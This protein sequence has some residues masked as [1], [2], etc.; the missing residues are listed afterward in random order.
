MMQK[1]ASKISNMSLGRDIPKD[2]VSNQQTYPAPDDS[3]EE[4]PA[5]ILVGSRYRNQ[6]DGTNDSEDDSQDSSQDGR[7]TAGSGATHAGTRSAGLAGPAGLITS[8]TIPVP[9]IASNP[10][11]SPRPAAPS[12]PSLPAPTVAT[13]LV[14]FEIPLED[15]KIQL[16]DNIDHARYRRIAES[17]DKY[18]W[19]DLIEA[20]YEDELVADSNVIRKYNK[21]QWFQHCEETLSTMH[22]EFLKAII[23]GDLVQTLCNNKAL[24]QISNGYNLQGSKQPCIYV[25]QL[26]LGQANE[27]LTIDQACN[28][29]LVAK[30][31]GNQLQQ[32]NDEAYAI[33]HDT[34]GTTWHRSKSDRGERAFLC[35][36]AGNFVPE[37]RRKILSFSRALEKT[38]SRAKAEGKTVIPALTYTGYTKNADTR[39]ASHNKLDDGTNWLVRFTMSVAKLLD[40]KPRMTMVVV[41]FLTSTEMASASEMLVTRLANS[42]YFAGGFSNAQAG[43]SVA[44]GSSVTDWAPY[45]KWVW[46]STA[47]EKTEDEEVQRRRFRQRRG[48]DTKEVNLEA[49]VEPYRKNKEV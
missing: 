1:L 42:Y 24:L 14:G 7:L 13:N 34:F 43:G 47:Y 29:A 9:A 17:M 4:L 18:G 45:K 30:Q 37:Y 8:Y 12:R 6:Y 38:A 48:H 11:P 27:H 15:G 40:W 35:N 46:Q 26:C 2:D 10:A 16:Q 32:K 20:A 36:K 33:D 44:S 3:Q 23:R 39:N 19:Y 21:D 31:Y 49:D 25:R 22:P 41:S 5:D 28:L